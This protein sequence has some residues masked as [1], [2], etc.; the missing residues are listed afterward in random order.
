MTITCFSYSNNNKVYDITFPTI[1]AYCEEHDYQFI[2][3]HTNLENKY[4]PHWNKLLYSIKLLK[5]SN[6][7]YIVW[8]DHDIV[9]KNY[10][11]KLQDIITRYKFDK[12]NSLFMM[13]RDPHSKYPFNTGVI[14]FKNNKETLHIFQELLDMRNNP[15]KY[16]LL[17]KYGGFDF[18]RG[19]QDTRVMLVYFYKNK[20]ALLSIPHKVLQSFYG[21]ENFYS[22][23]DFCGH[24]AGPQGELLISKLNELKNLPVD[25]EQDL[26]NLKKKN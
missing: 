2:P 16:P 24:V 20:D 8:F 11:I 23:G 6:S 21:K 22:P 25:I 5:E 3:Y 10:N 19:L 26:L 18:S 9:I 1:Q 4:K 13:S 14:V 12:S 17:N 15:H 7:D